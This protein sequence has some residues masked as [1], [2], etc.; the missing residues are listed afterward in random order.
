[1]SSN[2]ATNQQANLRTGPGEEFDKIGWIKAGRYV[3]VLTC[4]DDWSK[5]QVHGG[6]QNGTIAWVHNNLLRIV[7]G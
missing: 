4:D 7:K 1:M 5:V 3:T 6:D 2:V